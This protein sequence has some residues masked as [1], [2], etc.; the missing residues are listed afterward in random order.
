MKAKKMNYLK[1]TFHKF[2][3][4]FEELN[5]IYGEE[6]VEYLLD[7]A[8]INVDKMYSP[9]YLKFLVE[10]V[11]RLYESE[12]YH[13]TSSPPILSTGS[14]FQIQKKSPKWL[15]SDFEDYD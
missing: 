8:L 1:P 4:I 13:S 7:W 3:T 12:H 15:K 9:N 14:R 10:K 6:F 2:C 5:I 11:S